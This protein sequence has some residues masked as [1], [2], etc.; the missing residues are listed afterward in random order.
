[1]LITAR[2]SDDLFASK[3]PFGY[4]MGFV[5]LIGATCDRMDTYQSG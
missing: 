1:M 5:R 2:G 4:D 3:R